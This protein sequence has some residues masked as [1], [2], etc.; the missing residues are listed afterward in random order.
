MISDGD[1]VVAVEVK[2]RA[3]DLGRYE[4]MTFLPSDGVIVMEANHYA[5]KKGAAS[6][7]F[8][9]LKG[10]GRSG[11]GMKVL[12]S[13]EEFSEKDDKPEITYQFV[14]EKAGEHV[15][16]IWT[17]PVNS[18][19]NKRALRAVVG[20]GKQEKIVNILEADFRGGDYNDYRWSSA[21][22][23]QIHVV[24]TELPFEEGVQTLTIGALEAGMVLERILIYPAG[25]SLKPSYLGPEESC[26]KG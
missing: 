15:V 1:A 20:N 10:H 21:V 2:A 24:K 3:V 12:P 13:T 16:E 6:A 23:N 19:V 7:E 26:Y 11:N 25:K 5:K 17:S 9:L 4:E 14:I 18:L 8:V 22:M